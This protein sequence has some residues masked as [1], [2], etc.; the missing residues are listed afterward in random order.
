MENILSQIPESVIE[1]Y[2][3][4]EK[5]NSITMY[6]NPKLLIGFTSIPTSDLRIRET[7]NC[8]E[9]SEMG[10]FCLTLYKSVQASHMSIF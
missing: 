3:I 1:R 7:E 8:V 9:L 2:S 5:N 6:T 4:E 10:K